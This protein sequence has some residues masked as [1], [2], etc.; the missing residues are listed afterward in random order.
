[1]FAAWHV[2]KLASLARLR[3]L[4][5]WQARYADQ[6]N[7]KEHTDRYRSCGNSQFKAKQTPNKKSSVGRAV[8]A[9]STEEMLW[10]GADFQNLR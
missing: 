2:Q 3:I 7:E 8:E 4:R 10:V 6:V 9:T 1:M 5:K